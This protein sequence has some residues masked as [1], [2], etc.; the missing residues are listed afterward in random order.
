[1][2]APVSPTSPQATLP[3]LFRCRHRYG[4]G[5]VVTRLVCDVARSDTGRHLH[6]GATL[7]LRGR[8]TANPTKVGDAKLRGFHVIHTSAGRAAERIAHE[9]L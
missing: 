5:P 3:S 4:D 2:L 1:V 7:G 9:A 8:E 6:D